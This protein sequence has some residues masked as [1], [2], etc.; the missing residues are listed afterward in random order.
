MGL[1]GVAKDSAQSANTPASFQGP[2]LVLVEF[3]HEGGEQVVQPVRKCPLVS[4]ARIVSTATTWPRTSSSTGLVAPTAS[5]AEMTS[6]PSS[7][8]RSASSSRSREA[9]GTATTSSPP[10][11]T[12]TRCRRPAPAESA[13][14]SSL[15][16]ERE[17]RASHR[18]RGTRRAPPREGRPTP[19]VGTWCPPCHRS[20]AGTASRFRGNRLDHSPRRPDPRL[21]M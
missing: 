20:C 11:A 8:R 12:S 1:E 21:P 2:L 5:K 14:G 10:T 15:G 18:A 7:R 4:I 13:T 9:H 3:V 16:V 6:S 17:P 19:Q